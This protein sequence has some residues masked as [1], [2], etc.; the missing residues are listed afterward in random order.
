LTEE[1]AIELRPV[2]PGLGQ[3]TME[4]GVMKNLRHNAIL[5][6]QNKKHAQKSN[7]FL[8]GSKS[9]TPIFQ[10]SEPLLP[11]KANYL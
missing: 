9:S 10:Y 7:M 4:H 2:K 8:S 5:G 3:G 11:G 6:K 1:D